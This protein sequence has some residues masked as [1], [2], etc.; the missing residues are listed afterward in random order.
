MSMNKHLGAVA[1][2]SRSPRRKHLLESVGLAVEIVP[3]SY[4]ET[5]LDGLDP[6]QTALRHALGKAESADPTG[7][8]VLIAADTLVSLEGILLGKPSDPDHARSMLRQLAGRVH[9]VF[10]GYVVA[11]RSTGRSVSG[12]ESAAVHF[13]PLSEE[14]IV[15][16]VATGDPLDKAGAYG[17]LGLGG[18][19]V[20]SISGDFYTVVGLPLA[21]IGTSVQ[22]LGYN[23]LAI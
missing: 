9:Q 10:T 5:V 23:I 22:E 2:A 20:E 4:E 11:D 6:A 14:T 15:A 8:P 3:S 13:L 21:R 1:L 19:L 16:Y 12:V 17:I 7:P 18:L